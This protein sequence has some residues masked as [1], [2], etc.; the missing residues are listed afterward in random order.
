MTLETNQICSQEDLERNEC[1]A[2]APER[3]PQVSAIPV[4]AYV[5]VGGGSAIF[6]FG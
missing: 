1:E 4:E 5:Y 2:N 3:T 6:Q